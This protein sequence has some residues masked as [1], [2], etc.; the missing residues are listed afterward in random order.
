MYFLIYMY[1][2][3]FEWYADIELSSFQFSI[4]A[5]CIKYNYIFVPFNKKH[6]F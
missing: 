1:R 6:T 3:K 4:V 5:Q 2:F